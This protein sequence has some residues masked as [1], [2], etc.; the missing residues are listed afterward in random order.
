MAAVLGR[1]L[2]LSAQRV[3]GNR[4]RDEEVYFD[5]ERR[6]CLS[7]PFV[8]YYIVTFFL[9]GVSIAAS[10]VSQLQFHR[11]GG[12]NNW[13]DAYY[14][15]NAVF[16]TLHI[17]AALYIVQRIRHAPRNITPQASE[18]YVMA[19]E[20]APLPSA[21]LPQVHD[22][23]WW[24]KEARLND[25]NEKA[26]KQ[27]WWSK[28]KKVPPPQV[29]ATVVVLRETHEHESQNTTPPDSWPRIKNIL[30]EDK[31][32]AFYIVVF[33]VYVAWHFFANSGNIYSYNPGVRFVE[34]C[35]DIFV[36]AG[37]ASFCFS[38]IVMFM[39]KPQG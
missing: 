12:Y 35:S 10:I 23:P 33:G 14:F 21:P 30:L 25:A 32:V 28:N 29:V 36:L 34:K 9:N 7:S 24:L 4:K 6:G 26:G 39:N 38:I 19:P 8:S 5:D 13:V 20:E 2:N 3:G 22:E 17:L 16:G 1:T 15:S 18:A 11:G 31:V 27:P 37:P